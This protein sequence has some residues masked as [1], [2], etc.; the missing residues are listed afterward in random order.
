MN[1]TRYLCVLAAALW[2]V[3]L[4]CPAQSF[5]SK[6]VRIIVPWPPGGTTD[7]LG[8]M[9][10]A[11]LTE[12]WG[13]QTIVDNRPGAGGNL[14]F[15]L[16]AKSPADG[17]VM[18]IMTVA[19]TISPSIYNKLGFDVLGD[20][21]HV[22]LMA[23]V[24]SLLLVHPSLPAKNVKEFIA[25]ARAKPGALN[26]ASTGKGTSPH[27]MMEMFKTMTRTNLVH[28]PYKGVSLGMIDQISGLVEC[29]FGTA[30][31]ALPYVKQGKVRP[32]AVS[33]KTRF[34]PLAELPTLDEAGVR[35]F[36]ASSWT[37]MSMP[38]R[39]PRDVVQ[40]TNTELVRMLKAPEM[41][42]K[43]LGMGG[44]VVADTPDEFTAFVKQDV[45]RWA[46][47]ANAADMKRE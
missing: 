8:R 5:P 43:L 11:R 3:A 18:C 41:R 2:F 38:A 36:D 35:G 25:L 6:P 23:M 24:P 29:S 19:Q 42:E 21:S 17:H 32:L 9:A 47:V 40:K 1:R 39:T 10:A 37:G 7:I 27:M 28:I 26:Y 31:G 15:D 14:G 45:E 4:G 20:F 22:T 30:I 33:T 13:V 16:C 46:K 34:P 44:V 12:V